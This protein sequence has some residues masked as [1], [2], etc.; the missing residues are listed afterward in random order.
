MLVCVI[1]VGESPSESCESLDHGF[2]RVESVGLRLWGQGFFHGQPLH[3]LTALAECFAGDDPVLEGAFLKASEVGCLPFAE[4]V[5]CLDAC[6]DEGL[7]FLVDRGSARVALLDCFD[8]VREAFGSMKDGSDFLDILGYDGVAVGDPGNE[9]L[10]DPGHVGI[11]FDKPGNLV[12]GVKD[13]CVVSSVECAS[14]GGEGM[15][16]E[17]GCQEHGDMSGQGAVF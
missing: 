5:N 10:D 7:G 15:G 4:S 8:D 17:Y 3:L 6:C 2:W 14:Y 1:R 9:D 13:G 12:T 11:C 16:C